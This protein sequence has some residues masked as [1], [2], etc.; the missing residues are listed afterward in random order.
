MR[1]T[2]SQRL[3]GCGF[4]VGVG[5]VVIVLLGLELATDLTPFAASVSFLIVGLAAVTIAICFTVHQEGVAKR[6][7][8]DQAVH[9]KGRTAG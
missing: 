1:R 9:A 7:S 6:A 4:A 2:T 3:I 5:C 8:R